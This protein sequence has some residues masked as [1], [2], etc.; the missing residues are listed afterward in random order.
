MANTLSRLN[1]EQRAAATHPLGSPACVIAGAGSGKTATLTA[2]LA[3]LIAQG[4]PPRRTLTITF[5]NKAAAELKERVAKELGVEFDEKTSPRIGTI[6]SFAL[7]AIRKDSKG[8]GLAHRVSPLDDYGQGEMIER[9]IKRGGFKEAAG[10][11]IDPKDVPLLKHWDVK[12]KIQYHRARGVGFARDYTPEVHKEARKRHSG[13]HAMCPA[14]IEVWGLYEKEKMANSVVDF[15]DMLHLVVDRAKNDETWRLRLQSQFDTVLMDESQDTNPVQW[16]FFNLLFREDN[17]NAFVVGDMSQCQPPCTKVKVVVEPP[18]GSRPAVCEE[19]AIE[20]LRDGDKVVAWAKHDQI[21]YSAGREIRVASRPYDGPLIYI[22]TTEAA[23][24]CTPNHWN[25]VRFNSNVVGKHIVYLMH[26]EGLGFRVGISTFKRV[27]S[28]GR[29]GAYGLSYR[30]N[31]EKADKAWILRVCD[32]RADAETWEEI[33]SVKYG[34]PES[35]YEP[36]PC[37]NKT[38]DMIRLIFSFANPKGGMRCL[39]DHYLLWT[40]PLISR[41][42]KGEHGNSWRGFFKTAT[43][44]II[45]G[46]MDIPVEGRNKA[47]PIHTLTRRHYKGPVYSLEVEK[48]HT[49]IADGLVVG[50]SIYAFNGAAPHLLK[51]YSEGWRGKVPSPYKLASN[52]RSVPEVVN[53]ANAIQKKM[54]ETIPLSMKSARGAKGEKG[55]TRILRSDTPRNVAAQIV[56]EI[57]NGNKRVR[58]KVAYRDNAILVRSA[59]QIRDVESELVR[60]RIPYIIRGGRGLLQTEEVR[61]LLAYLRFAANTRD[62]EAFARAVSAPRRGVGDAAVE[63]V[64]AV[65]IKDFDGDILAGSDKVGHAKLGGFNDTI[66]GAIRAGNP[67]DALNYIIISSG[68]V[69]YIKERYRKEMDKVE[70]KIDNIS[71]FKEMIQGLLEFKPE[72]TLEDMVFQFT[73]HEKEEKKSEDEDD[74]AVIISTIHSSKGLEWRR[75]YVVNCYEGSLPHVYCREPNEIE[76][77]RR[78]FYVAV[79]RG[80]DDVAVCIPAMLVRGPNFV[81]AQPSRFLI[82]LGL[83]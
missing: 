41:E 31:Q 30:F 68:Y 50:N 11:D 54:T 26:R 15:D 39:K 10:D 46:I 16:E 67:L 47:V 58:D 1:D 2:R 66:R 34:I 37:V 14:E 49:Y 29:T 38:A 81:P 27:T 69:N 79:T 25:W 72:T 83:I 18:R 17:F 20:T 9:I 63:K 13:I 48:E 12:D 65:A 75:V 7:N 56:T 23:T 40:H 55:L 42:T 21:T 53:L 70:M 32:S 64:R 28:K 57:F 19:R 51:A 22:Q 80:M 43:A 73:L 82:E 33:Y 45:P 78:L 60:L 36:A 71:R 24:E 6:H 62:S 59:T 74:G 77:E 8:F 44:N 61:D 5:T 76:E 35:L 4:V 52:Y 3:W